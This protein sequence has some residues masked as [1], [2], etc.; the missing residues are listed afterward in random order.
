MAFGLYSLL[1][2]ALLVLNAM[3]VLHEERFLAK[4]SKFVVTKAGEMESHSCLQRQCAADGM[5]SSNLLLSPLSLGVTEGREISENKL[6]TEISFLPFFND[7]L[8]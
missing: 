2:A 5:Q 7:D 1:E 4:V 8:D 3:C 6:T